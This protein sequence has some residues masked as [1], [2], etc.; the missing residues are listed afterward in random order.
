MVRNNIMIK[1]MPQH[2]N[3]YLPKEEWI[4]QDK[5]GAVQVSRWLVRGG[6][7]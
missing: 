2:L 7:T 5:A 6:G 1:D 3:N 4:S